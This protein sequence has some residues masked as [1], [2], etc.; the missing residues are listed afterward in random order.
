M[1]LFYNSYFNIYCH[2]RLVHGVIRS[3]YI[4]L[5][6]PSP[7]FSSGT[8]GGSVDRKKSDKTCSANLRKLTTIGTAESRRALEDLVRR[9]DDDKADDDSGEE[10]HADGE[11]HLTTAKFNDRSSD[12]RCPWTVIDIVF[13]PILHHHH[14]RLHA[15]GSVDMPTTT[16]SPNTDISSAV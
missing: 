12:D 5:S 11:E 4:G 15:Y 13:I 1:V 6:I 14:L 7:N 9:E 10:E 3:A 16:V 2:T 8:S